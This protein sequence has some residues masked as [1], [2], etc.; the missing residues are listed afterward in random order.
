ML[1]H[2][3]FLMS[4]GFQKMR[5]ERNLKMNCPP[6][7]NHKERLVQCYRSMVKVKDI[8]CKKRL[9]WTQRHKCN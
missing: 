2:Q 6:V 5:V 4:C 1:F 8:H 3:N 9:Q 7:S